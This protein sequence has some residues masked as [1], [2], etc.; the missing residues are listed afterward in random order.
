MK[1]DSP[2]HTDFLIIGGGIAG[3]RAALALGKS[4]RVFM[5][6]KDRNLESSS[7]YAQGGIAVAIGE[8]DRTED[9]L[10]DTLRAGAGLCNR[11]AVKILV[12]EGPLRVDELIRWGASF[13]RD[14][15]RFSLGREGAHG[16]RRILHAKDATGEE[17]VRTLLRRVEEESS[18]ERR[19]VH[20]TVDLILSDGVCYGAF[21]LDE[22]SG[23]FIPVLSKATLLATGG[24]GQVYARTT[25]P[26]GATG[27]GAAMAYRA[28]GVVEDME[29]VQFHPTALC[30]SGAPPFLITEALRG[31]GGILRN[32]KG[33]RFMPLYHPQEELA[34][35]DVVSR[36][37]LR[38]MTRTGSSHVLLDATALGPE[39]I[40]KKFPTIHQVCL[41]FGVDMTRNPIPVSPS[42]HFF[43]GG[44]KTDLRGKTDIE[45]LF[46]A[47]EV[48]CTGIHGANRLASNS[49]LEG[50]VFGARAGRAAA[51]HSGKTVF[52]SP[53]PDTAALRTPP[54]PPGSSPDK[55]FVQRLMWEKAGIIRSRS[56]LEE[57]SA[58]LE[59]W[60]S[61]HPP[62]P[63]LTRQEWEFQNILTVSSLVVQAALMR[64]ES[65]GVH[66]R[67]DFPQMAERRRHFPLQKAV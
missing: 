40:R 50:L 57:A 20:F 46:A 3:L 1:I 39:F 66:Y 54:R 13:D 25:N 34:P 58:A 48:A 23:R 16:R 17:I 59:E 24:A 31:E 53:I 41:K 21:L 49:L 18:I 36:A 65:V 63:F 42:A 55:T 5:A 29:F 12:E 8:D 64:E 67:E 9:H 61:L 14:H 27:D 15:G 45:R 37:I 44:V 7:G 19:L 52:P 56:S 33:E 2:L 43:I 22:S 38:E 47:G 35:R 28:G 51:E 30:V 26:P 11:E 6:A 62:A 60:R 4:G 10:E 32:V